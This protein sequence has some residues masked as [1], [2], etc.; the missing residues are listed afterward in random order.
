MI[1]SFF[2]FLFVAEYLEAGGAKKT[3]QCDEM[4]VPSWFHFLEKVVI[5]LTAISS[6][7]SLVYN[8]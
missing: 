7:L 8:L 3:V 1:D 5:I 4:V 6:W 2:F